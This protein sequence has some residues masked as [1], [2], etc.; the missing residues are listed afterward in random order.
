VTA[1]KQD[2]LSTLEKVAD[3]SRNIWILGGTGFIG[4]SL[5]E[6]L[7]SDPL[8][9]IHLLIHKNIPYRRLEK[10]H[11]ISGN[12]TSM[13]LSWF[14]QFPPDVIFHLARMAGRGT[15]HRRLTS[16]RGS[17]ANRRL[18]SYL[19]KLDNPPMVVYVSGSLMYG[20]QPGNI[21]AD[22]NTQLNPVAYGREYQRAEQPWL[23]ANEYGLPVKIVRPAWIIGPGSWFTSF[24]WDH[25]SRTGKVPVYG[26]GRQLMSLIH[27]EDLGNMIARVPES[28]VSVLNLYRG[29][30]LS[31][32]EF[33]KTMAE[34]L[35]A[36]L[37][38]IGSRQ[39]R[40]KYGK[41]AEEALLTSIPLRTLESQFW[42]NFEFKYPDAEKMLRSV[43]DSLK[44]E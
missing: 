13:D 38:F 36:Q 10:F 5:L 24:Y 32:L 44:S 37:D 31:Q 23:T 28:S 41:A 33:S 20:S 17:L 7:S 9:R 18:I 29:N 8:N 30:P 11:T 34:I 21:P 4:R 42:S 39:V 26:D 27:V 25:Y 1:L 16:I 6:A 43:I 22:E 15:L 19:S 12:L 40:K 3:A 35:G 2:D 14:D